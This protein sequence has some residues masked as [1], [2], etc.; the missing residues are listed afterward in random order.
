MLV[1]CKITQIPMLI[2]RPPLARPLLP[3][4]AARTHGL[5]PS[6]RLRLLSH[7]HTAA[8][9][10]PNDAAARSSSSIST[11]RL[12]IASLIPHAYLSLSLSLARPD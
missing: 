6:L 11:T 7:P 9:A 12:G 2:V 4:A 5:L 3:V 1:E 8:D 10:W